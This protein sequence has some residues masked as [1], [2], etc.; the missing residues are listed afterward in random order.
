MA[1]GRE[2]TFVG[3]VVLNSGFGLTQLSCVD[4]SDATVCY[5]LEDCVLPICDAVREKW[6][7]SLFD[8]PMAQS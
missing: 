1:I 4:S 8:C 3:G 2:T 5:E 7:P 6:D